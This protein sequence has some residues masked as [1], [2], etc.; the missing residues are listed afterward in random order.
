MVSTPYTL[1]MVHSSERRM[2]SFLDNL[3]LLPHGNI[4]FETLESGNVILKFNNV[5]LSEFR[6]EEV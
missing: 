2:K 6:I 5:I 3:G 1:F 4:V